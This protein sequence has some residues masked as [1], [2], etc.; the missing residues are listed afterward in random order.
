MIGAQSPL[1]LHLKDVGLFRGGKQVL[2][3][4]TASFNAT[5]V[6]TVIIGPN[7][8]G[9]S[10]LLHICHGL[11]PPDAGIVEWSGPH[12][13]DALSRTQ[14]MVFQRPVLFR[15]SAIANV[16]LALKIA[17]FPKQEW[18][19]RADDIL[20]RTGLSRHA[21]T[22]ARALS[23]GEQQRLA[24]ARALVIEPSV[25]FLDEPTA[26]LDPAAA[27][28]VE[29]LIEDAAVGG[30]KIIMTSHDLNQTRRLADEIIFM[31]RG[32]IKE[33]APADQFFTRPE[34][35]L[36]QAFINGELLWWRRRSMFDGAPTD[37]FGDDRTD[38]TAP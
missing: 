34:N 36:A 21:T 15:R 20:Y 1:P 30:V 16:V 12:D 35:D 28:L 3:D 8:A 5:P 10:L 26:S 7:G 33:R 17:G 6:K 13:S 9:K 32:R 23:F 31:H 2:K 24:L 19:D 4:I 29:Q 38:G 18:R 25:L 14:S 11:V 22:P 37:G 27:H